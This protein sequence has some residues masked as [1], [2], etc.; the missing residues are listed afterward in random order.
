MDKCLSHHIEAGDCPPPCYEK[1]FDYNGKTLFYCATTSEEIID[2]CNFLHNEKASFDAA[3]CSAIF[4]CDGSV[5]FEIDY[6]PYTACA[7]VFDEGESADEEQETDEVQDEITKIE[8]KETKLDEVKD[9]NEEDSEPSESNHFAIGGI[10]IIVLIFLYFAISVFIT[11][12]A[13]FFY[14][15]NK[16]RNGADGLEFNFPRCG[17][18]ILY[19]LYLAAV[20][21]VGLSLMIGVSIFVPVVFVAAYLVTNISIC[22]SGQYCAMMH[23]ADVEAGDRY[24]RS[25]RETQ[26]Q[27]HYDIRCW[28][29]EVTLT[30]HVDDDGHVWTERSERTVMTYKAT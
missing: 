4:G 30:H 19:L 21:F 2:V 3:M 25:M 8:G 20:F 29:V 6:T 17:W 14:V 28:H 15:R 12:L 1:S 22:W 13:V 23:L 5:D 27:L 16:R 9:A 10:L 11:G 7:S 24:A 26:P 18:F